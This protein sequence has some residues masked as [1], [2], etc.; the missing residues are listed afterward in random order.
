[1]SRVN[2]KKWQCRMLLSL[3]FPGV[4]SQI[5]GMLM[6][7]VAISLES[8]SHETRLRR[9][10]FRVQT[11]IHYRKEMPPCYYELV[12]GTIHSMVTSRTCWMSNLY[13]GKDVNCC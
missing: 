1:M 4:R 2:F 5:Q 3:I 6:P 13:L 9:V 12:F 8:M 11:Q 10:D 7:P